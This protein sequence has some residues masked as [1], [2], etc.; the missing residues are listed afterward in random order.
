MLKTLKKPKQDFTHT[1]NLEYCMKSGFLLC[2]TKHKTVFQCFPQT[3][4]KVIFPSL[5]AKLNH[6][7]WSFTNYFQKSDFFFALTYDQ[8][9]F[10]TSFPL[11]TT[12]LLLLLL[13]PHP[14]NFCRQKIAWVK[15][16][17]FPLL[18]CSIFSPLF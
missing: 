11:L 1:N 12:L 5:H 10:S 8:K 14:D 16:F 13:R 17:L 2:F 3:L 7:G 15:P 4:A 9:L 18:F 6:G